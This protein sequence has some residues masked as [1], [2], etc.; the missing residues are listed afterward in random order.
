MIEDEKATA[1]LYEVQKIREITESQEQ[2]R[3]ITALLRKLNAPDY[4]IDQRA[5][6]EH[7]GN[8]SAGSWVW[9]NEKFQKWADIGRTDNPYLYIHGSPG[10]GNTKDI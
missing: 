5:A 8:N 2:T 10:S 4:E 3:Q 1:T 6:S 9:D 7:R